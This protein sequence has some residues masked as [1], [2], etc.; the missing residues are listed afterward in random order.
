MTDR[1]TLATCSGQRY[2]RDAIS[3]DWVPL[4]VAL[5][6]SVVVV[7]FEWRAMRAVSVRRVLRRLERDRSFRV[8][9][10]RL[11]NVWTPAVATSGSRI[12]S[13]Y[14]QMIGKGWATYTLDDDGVVQLHWEGKHGGQHFTGGVLAPRTPSG[15][16]TPAE[17]R[18]RTLIRNVVI[19]YVGW[20]LVG[21]TVGYLLA[22]G[23]Q[24]RRL[25]FAGVGLFLALLLA[26]LSSTAIRVALAVRSALRD[27]H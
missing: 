16:D 20:L 19:G 18:R 4:P 8:R 1:G 26:A 13:G 9:T 17:I 10:G 23:S 22:D 25:V 24:K 5:A 21:A 3:V 12:G 2:A 14:M 15:V 6:L 11:S 27:R 7:R